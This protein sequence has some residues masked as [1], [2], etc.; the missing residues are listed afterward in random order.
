MHHPSS[1]SLKFAKRFEEVESTSPLC[2]L[3]DRQTDKSIVA[4]T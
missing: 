3:I 1:R 4:D 2:L